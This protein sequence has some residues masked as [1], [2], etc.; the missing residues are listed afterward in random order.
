LL[1]KI[2]GLP[3]TARVSSAKK[4]REI[5]MP[6]IVITPTLAYEILKCTVIGEG[7]VFVIA[8]RDEF[9]RVLLSELDRVRSV[10]ESD[11]DDE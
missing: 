10:F 2:L 9:A 6:G 5:M 7:K 3:D 1:K 11:E 4:M 8:A